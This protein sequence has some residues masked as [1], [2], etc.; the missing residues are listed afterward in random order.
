MKPFR[1]AFD[2][3]CLLA[4]ASYTLNRWLIPAP[5]KGWFLRNY[6]D[7][8]LLIPAALPLILWIQRRTGLRT[9]DVQPE[10]SEII[11]HL[12]VWS[13][14]AE[15]I[16]PRFFTHAVADPWDI[17]AYTG[18]ALIAGLIWHRS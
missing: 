15:V 9:S 5:W 12:V 13:V 3:L 8:T 1:Y 7:D 18:G 4:C 17:L 6:F 14:A 10:W 16:A 11:F 2:L